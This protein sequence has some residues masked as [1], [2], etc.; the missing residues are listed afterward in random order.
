MQSTRPCPRFNATREGLLAPP[1]AAQLPAK[2][3]ARVSP[4]PLPGLSLSPSSTAGPPPPPCPWAPAPQLAPPPVPGSPLSLAPPRPWAPSH[5]QVRAVRGHLLAQAGDGAAGVLL[6]HHLAQRL[7]GLVGGL[8]TLG[9]HRGAALG[10]LDVDSLLVGDAWCGGT[11]SSGRLRQE[12]A[13]PSTMAAAPMVVPSTVIPPL[14]LGGEGFNGSMF[15]RTQFKRTQRC[16]QGSVPTV[17]AALSHPCSD[18]TA[19]PPHFHCAAVP[20]LALTVTLIIT[21]KLVWH[22]LSWRCAPAPPSH[23]CERPPHTPGARPARPRTAVLV[24]VLGIQVAGLR[25]EDVAV[26]VLPQEA[27]DSRSRTGAGQ[28]RR[29][30]R[31]PLLCCP[32]AAAL[33]CTAARRHKSNES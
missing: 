16:C 7:R 23:A 14:L 21:V 11:G 26:Q 15:V 5:L 2:A 17:T 33:R 28:G 22:L 31:A 24:R 3:A 1:A 18:T 32:V 8:G 10:S 30:L 9:G 4:P 20:L 12:G 29:S 6:G 13:K 27:A 25:R 19:G